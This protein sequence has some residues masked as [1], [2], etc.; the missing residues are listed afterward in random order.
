MFL[1][2]QNIVQR[3]NSNQCIEFLKVVVLFV[4]NKSHVYFVKKEMQLAQDWKNISAFKIS[5]K[6]VCAKSLGFIDI[7]KLI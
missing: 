2:L 6:L 7:G 1:I 4:L 3:L 5:R